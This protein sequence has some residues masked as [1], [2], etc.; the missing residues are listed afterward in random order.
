MTLVRQRN[1]SVAER[2]PHVPR[3]SPRSDARRRAEVSTTPRGAVR[4]S[5]TINNR[6]PSL[7][8]DESGRSDL[9]PAKLRE[10]RLT[11]ALDRA[12]GSL[13]RRDRSVNRLDDV[14]PWGRRQMHA[15]HDVDAQALAPHGAHRFGEVLGQE[16]LTTRTSRE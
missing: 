16:E 5:L 2:E 7:R 10:L 6:L 9:T 1:G 3:A 11:K 4:R 12:D 14:S 8:C 13:T 15:E